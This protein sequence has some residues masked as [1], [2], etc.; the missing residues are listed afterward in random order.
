MNG[1]QR[2]LDL[3]DALELEQEVQQGLE[4]IP[5]WLEENSLQAQTLLDL[6]LRQ[7]IA[8]LHTPRALL[9]QDRM[10][11]DQRYSIL[12]CLETSTTTIERHIALLEVGNYSLCCIRSDYYRSA[13]LICHIA[14]YAA[15]ASG[16]V[17]R[18]TLTNS[19][20]C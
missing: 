10:R 11:S 7:F 12:T 4:N 16:T 3:Q 8:I 6:Q 18:K 20:L 19:L 13:L 14:Y 17:T 9:P 2:S 1:L 15:T 5:T